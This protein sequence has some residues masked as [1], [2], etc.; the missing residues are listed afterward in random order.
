MSKVGP[1]GSG[2][3]SPST[4]PDTSDCVINRH[5]DLVD[6]MMTAVN[7][8]QVC[9]SLATPDVDDLYNRSC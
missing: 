9:W 1:G 6:E 4:H 5:D 7:E 8:D 2:C 3:F